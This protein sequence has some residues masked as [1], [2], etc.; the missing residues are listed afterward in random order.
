MYTEIFPKHNVIY[1]ADGTFLNVDDFAL[2]HP[3]SYQERVRNFC[4]SHMKMSGEFQDFDFTIEEETFLRA[5]FIMS[6]GLF[7][8][9]A[10]SY[11]YAL[12][13]HLKSIP[14]RAV[15]FMGKIVTEKASK[16]VTHA[17]VGW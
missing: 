9:F 10:S 7:S 14:S 11:A 15:S 17:S 5:V 13:Y 6:P 8:V 4:S 1:Q 3:N 12:Q 16:S 2:D